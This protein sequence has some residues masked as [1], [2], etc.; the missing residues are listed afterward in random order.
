MGPLK[1][2][3]EE[4]LHHA[5]DEDWLAAWIKAEE[6]DNEDLR[7]YIERLAQD[8]SLEADK[9]IRAGLK[10]QNRAKALRTVRNVKR[11]LLA[12]LLHKAGIIDISDSSGMKF[13]TM[14]NLANYYLNNNKENTNG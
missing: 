1:S 9:L 11:R 3:Y 12:A 10:V 4:C 2:Q 6:I 13:K 8:R 5:A 7:D 14:A